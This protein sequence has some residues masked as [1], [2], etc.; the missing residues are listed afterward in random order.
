MRMTIA[1]PTG[2]FGRGHDDHEKDEHLPLKLAQRATEAHE[3]QVNGVE[4]QLNRHENCQ[5]VSFK[6][7]R[8]HAQSEQD[9]A[10]HK[11]I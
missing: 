4:H 9:C 10:E 8:D 7:E 3:S 6:D 11:K 1:R 2:G 5:D